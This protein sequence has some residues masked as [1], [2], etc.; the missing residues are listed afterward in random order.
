VKF[1]LGDLL[2]K[3][4]IAF[5]IREVKKGKKSTTYGLQKIY[6]HIPGKTEFIDRFPYM[7]HQGE[8]IYLYNEDILKYFDDFSRTYCAA[9]IFTTSID[10]IQLRYAAR[11][12]FLIEKANLIHRRK[13]GI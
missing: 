12:E 2:Y 1:K 10:M 13:S 3:E 5:Q 7:A 8:T 11:R 9:L 6:C 4:S